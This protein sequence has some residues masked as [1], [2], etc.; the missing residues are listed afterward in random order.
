[1][2]ENKKGDGK[3]VMV[4]VGT[5]VY[6]F[7]IYPR[8]HYGDKLDETRVRN[9]R[10]VLRSGTE[11]N[12]ALDVDKKTNCVVDGFHRG[13]AMEKERGA[14]ALIAVIYRRYKDRAAMLEESG[15]INNSHGK[16]MDRQDQIHFALKCEKHGISLAKIAGILSLPE[17]MLVSFLDQR[18]ALSDDGESIAIKNIVGHMAGETFTEKQEEVHKGLGGSS[19]VFLVNQLISLLRNGMTNKKNARLMERLGDLESE[20]GK[21]FRKNK[22]G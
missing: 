4:K 13:H 9:L 18:T 10:Y 19:Q 5:L 22:A 14:D 20:L 8:Q 11:F 17:K 15:R 1:M 12:D 7:E 21:F 3:I 2:A 16:P 6:D